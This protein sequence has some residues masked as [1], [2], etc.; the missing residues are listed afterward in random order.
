MRKLLS[1]AFSDAA[2][3][4]QE[5][6]VSQYFDLLIEKL[7]QQVDGPNKGKVDITAWYNFT[8]FDIVGDL[9]FGEPFG[10]L[11]ECEYHFWVATVFSVLR[12]GRV[13]R[14]ANRYKW[15][16]L[17]FSA[18]YNLVPAFGEFRKKMMDFEQNRAQTRL[19]TKVDRKDFIS[20][21]SFT[22]FL[23]SQRRFAVQILTGARR[24]FGTTT[25]GA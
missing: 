19:A 21:V 17:L 12:F 3:R 11:K 22:Q 9:A 18:L 24:F 10:A 16:G 1:H 8:T 4:E 5:P 20:Y 23:S 2:L 14:L 7:E 13:I 6:L 15:F 25:K